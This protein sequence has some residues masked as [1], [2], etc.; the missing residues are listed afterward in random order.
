[1][2]LANDPF[3]EFV[4]QFWQEHAMGICGL[5]RNSNLGVTLNGSIEDE[6]WLK[7]IGLANKDSKTMFEM[8]RVDHVA[9]TMIL[10]SQAI[11]SNGASTAQ[12]DREL[13]HL[14]LF[15]WLLHFLFFSF[16]LEIDMEHR[17]WAFMQ[18]HPAH[19]VLPPNARSAAINTLAWAWTGT[20]LSAPILVINMSIICI[21]GC[22]SPSIFA[23]F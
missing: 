1:M 14:R 6:I 23:S 10:A 16:S 12:E 19:T 5:H 17:Y 3:L 15:G 8:W 2:D 13:F 11:D 4:E 7:D 9:R 21:R 18:S 22:R 20:L